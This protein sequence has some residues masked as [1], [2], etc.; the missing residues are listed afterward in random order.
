M[1]LTQRLNDS[2][3][4]FVA[5]LG[6]GRDK[7][8]HSHYGQSLLTDEQLSDAY[9]YAWLPRK[10]VDIPAKDACRKWRNWQAE[11]D[12][13]TAIERVE[14]QI[15]VQRKTMEA[16][17]KARLFGGAAIYIGTTDP[18]PALPLTE[19]SELRHLTVMTR[20][21]VAPR[22]LDQDP[23]SPN[24]GKPRMYQVSG[25]GNIQE[26]HPTRLV[27]FKGSKLPDDE[28]ATARE[29][30][31]GDSV[32]ASVYD[33]VRNAD[34]TALNVASLIFEAKV[35]VI[36]IPDL[37]ASLTDPDYEAQLLKR[38]ALAAT[39]K[40]INGALL[41][42][43]LEDYQQKN[44]NFSSLKDIM[45]AFMQIVSGAA[46]I[47]MTRLLGQSPGG[48]Q[49]TGDADTR[50]YYDMVNADQELEMRP[51]LARLD[52]LIIRRALG[53]RPPEIW[54]KWAPLWQISETEQSKISKET[55]ETI[56]ILGETM[57][58]PEDALAQSATNML[59]ERGIMPG[60]DQEIQTG[61][62]SD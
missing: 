8:S 15:A 54:Y 38:M 32:L 13:I 52:E 29:Y 36:K 43:A 5:N 57:L 2:L 25:S 58:F 60:L 31:W 21:Q 55:A 45:M 49:S 39:A 50:N 61:G 9:R 28:L 59:V 17:T 53:D 24:Y 35:D 37:M 62:D 7:A 33:A 14:T 51:A 16:M 47:P 18:N 23:E 12:Q 10:I 26:V 34:A 46:D 48:L 20:R 30:G 27:V 22:E 41:I 1:K 19:R 4:N 3:R 42:D 56:K 40:G 44:A 6:T 11:A